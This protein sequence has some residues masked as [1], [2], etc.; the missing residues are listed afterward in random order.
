[1]YHFNI[2]NLRE[3]PDEEVDG[4]QGSGV[5][6]V[7]ARRSDPGGGHQIERNLKKDPP[8]NPATILENGEFFF[9]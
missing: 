2:V 9:Y 3:A 5:G 4:D 8:S 6:V 1:M 7:H